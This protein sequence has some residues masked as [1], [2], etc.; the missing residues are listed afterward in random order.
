MASAPAGFANGSAWKPGEKISIRDGYGKGL[1]E[2]GKTHADVVALDAD[3]AESTRS[4]WF[5]K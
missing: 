1:L 2:L 5:A 3:L 4:H